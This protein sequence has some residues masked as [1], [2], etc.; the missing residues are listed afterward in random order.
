MDRVAVELRR[1]RWW[2]VLDVQ[3]AS[4][5]ICVA[6]AAR[7]VS[8]C[9]LFK[10]IKI[11]YNWSK[12]FV[13]VC[14]FQSF[15]RLNICTRLLNTVERRTNVDRY[16]VPNVAVLCSCVDT[17]TVSCFQMLILCCLSIQFVHAM[18]TPFVQSWQ[19]CQRPV[20]RFRGWGSGSHL[21]SESCFIPPVLSWY[22]FKYC[23]VDMTDVTGHK[24]EYCRSHSSSCDAGTKGCRKS[25]WGWPKYYHAFIDIF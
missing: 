9:K 20:H 19:K 15:T 3:I 25:S 21:C 8:E 23:Y 1:C 4:M 13:F 22:F 7:V 17:E 18:E 6:H 16:P 11:T 12:G 14:S 24:D 10:L 5:E 2:A